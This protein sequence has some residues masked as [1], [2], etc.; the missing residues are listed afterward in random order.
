MLPSYRVTRRSLLFAEMTAS[1]LLEL[2]EELL[3]SILDYLAKPELQV[4]SLA[5]RSCRELATPL[6][7]REVELTDCRTFYTESGAVHSSGPGSGGTVGRIPAGA[8]V[9]SDEHD[10]T[11]LIKKLWVLAM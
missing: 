3:Q 2:P 10:D 4:L 7:W 9:R 8:V 5:S 11:P 6:V 1:S